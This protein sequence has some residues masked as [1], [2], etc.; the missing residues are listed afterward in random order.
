MADEAAHGSVMHRDGY[1][2]MVLELL[3]CI[4]EL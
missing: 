1:M 3:I 4:A 2:T